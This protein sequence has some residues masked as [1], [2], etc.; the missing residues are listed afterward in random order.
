MVAASVL[1]NDVVLRVVLSGMEA[2]FKASNKDSRVAERSG[3]PGIGGIGMVP[4]WGCSGISATA[5]SGWSCVDSI[6]G[7]CS[8]DSVGLAGIVGVVKN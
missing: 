7:D 8:R 1:G 5:A 4:G 2:L 3:T 6:R